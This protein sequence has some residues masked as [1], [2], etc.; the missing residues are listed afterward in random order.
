VTARGRPRGFDRSL[1]LGAATEVFW[2]KGFTATSI[3]DLC[4]AMRI[5]SPSLYAAFSSK[6]ALY[7]EAIRHY[8]ATYAPQIW[9]S[10]ATAPTAQEAVAAFL[11][12]S[13]AILPATAKPG[14][15]MVTLSTV[16][17]EGCARLGEFVSA[18]RR[19]GLTKIRTR[20]EAAV[21]E[22]EIAADVD[23][24]SVA[25]FYLG[26]QQGMSIQARDGA[27]RDELEAMAQAAM[28]SWPVLTQRRGKDA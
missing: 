28:E 11:M 16:G 9:G 18:V 19:A 15:C 6:E 12:A 10:F 20:L 4:A 7:E 3:A 2:R 13:A 27:S 24:R 5:N 23:L 21:A 8:E 1:A 25:R 17:E 26:V 14:G 22:G